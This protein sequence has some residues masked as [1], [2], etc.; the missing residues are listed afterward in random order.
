MNAIRVVVADDH[1]VV[2]R[3]VVS[4]LESQGGCAVVGEAANGREAV[5]LA[6]T[7]KPDVVVLDISMP[8]LSGIEAT[9]QI[10]EAV[11]ETEVLILTMHESD[12]LV[13]RL[14]EAGARGYVSKSDVGRNLIDAVQA[15]RRHQVFL[16]SSAAAAVVGDYLRAGGETKPDTELT[17]RQLEVLQLLTEGKGN[18]EIATILGVS[19]FTAETH[20]RNIMRKLDCHSV[21]QLIR[22]SM[23]NQLFDAH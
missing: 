5:M 7:L 15:L 10:L 14:L 8:E 12:A 4:L 1:E 21:A 19:V 16:T 22:Y 9:R 6:R 18:K 2:R 20:R 11:P 3:G 13:R 17:P 23:Q